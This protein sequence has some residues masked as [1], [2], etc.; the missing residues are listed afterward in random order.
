[1]KAGQCMVQAGAR[2]ILSVFSKRPPSP[3]VMRGPDATNRA[4]R[5][6]RPV[7]QYRVRADYAKPIW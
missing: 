1:M 7:R 6:G 5:S 2:F 4:P 3:R